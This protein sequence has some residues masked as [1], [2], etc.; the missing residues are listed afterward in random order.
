MTGECL[1][2]WSMMNGYGS[3]T[4]VS[5]THLD[6]Y[7]RQLYLFAVVLGLL[8]VVF[9]LTIEQAGHQVNC[10]SYVLYIFRTIVHQ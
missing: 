5:Y 7:K 9:S 4:S 2:M 10:L 1:S 6:V 3:D 8:K